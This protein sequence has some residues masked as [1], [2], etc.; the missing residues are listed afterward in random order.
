MYRLL[1]V[2]Y[3]N[4]PAGSSITSQILDFNSPG[5]ADVAHDRLIKQYA[6]KACSVGVTKLYGIAGTHEHTDIIPA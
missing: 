3:I 6:S 1:F 2:V 5:M 4:H